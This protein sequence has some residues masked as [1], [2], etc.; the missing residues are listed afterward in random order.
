MKL[1]Y[2]GINKGII[3]LQNQQ[4]K[5]NVDI[6]QDYAFKVTALSWGPQ[7][8]SQGTLGTVTD[9][10]HQYCGHRQPLQS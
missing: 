10:E 1:N 7:S 9:L 8:A 6:Q 4:G 2:K 3:K 5:Q